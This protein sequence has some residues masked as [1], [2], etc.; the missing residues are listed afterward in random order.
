MANIAESALE[1][2]EIL[3]DVLGVLEGVDKASLRG[4]I[5]C[6]WDYLR[7][8]GRAFREYRNQEIN[9]LELGVFA[10][11]S[12]RLWPRYFSKAMIVGIDIN[13]ACTK[14][15][16]GRSQVRIGS[17]D[18]KEFLTEVTKDFPPK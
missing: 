6:A 16:G 3:L 1:D 17:Q 9:I 4:D 7:H 12:L 18:D 14:Y 11:A 8:Y 10:G 5:H 13:S 15:S 2:D